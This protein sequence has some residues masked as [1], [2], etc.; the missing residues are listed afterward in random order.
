MLSVAGVDPEL[1]IAV[2]VGDEIEC[3]KPSVNPSKYRGMIGTV[4]EVDDSS[5][6]YLVDFKGLDLIWCHEVKFIRRP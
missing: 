5:A 3:V 4:L 6:P 1:G 2:Q